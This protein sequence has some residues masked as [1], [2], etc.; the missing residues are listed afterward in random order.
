VNPIYQVEVSA[1]SSVTNQM[2][3]SYETNDHMNS[4]F[5]YSQIQM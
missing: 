3:V 4:I 1:A 2:K 5:N